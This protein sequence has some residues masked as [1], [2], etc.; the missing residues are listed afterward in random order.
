MNTKLRIMMAVVTTCMVVAGLNYYLDLGWFGS[1]AKLVMASLQL[2]TMACL[3]VS[4]R[5]WKDKS[6]NSK[7]EH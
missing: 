4:L 5:L 7:D 6:S 2:M 1:R 3:L